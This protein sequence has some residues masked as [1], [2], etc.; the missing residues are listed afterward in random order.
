MKFQDLCTHIEFNFPPQIGI[1][2]ESLIPFA[3]P[4]CIHL[5]S[6]LLTYDSEDRITAE[7]ALC[8]EYF[9]EVWEFN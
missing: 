9:D 4:E 2:F 3:E 1:G 6:C 5:I 7:E 8:H